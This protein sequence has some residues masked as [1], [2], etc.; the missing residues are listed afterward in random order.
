[1]SDRESDPQEETLRGQAEP[2]DREVPQLDEAE[3]T[4]TADGVGVDTAIGGGSPA[5]A[6]LV[7]PSRAAEKAGD[8]ERHLEEGGAP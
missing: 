1:M 4:A 8:L 3:L 7:N 6:G 5:E 2:G